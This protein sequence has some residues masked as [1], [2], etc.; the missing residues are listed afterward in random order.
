MT[1]GRGLGPWGSG[2]L[3][4]TDQQLAPIA[5]TPFTFDFSDELDGP[6]P[7]L[8]ESYVLDTDAAGDVVVTAEP[9]P[10]D[11]YSV[12]GG[13]G[14][15]EFVRTPVS[16]GPGVPFTE[17]GV[18]AGPSATLEG[19]NARVSIIAVSPT[20]ILDDTQDELFYEIAVGLRFEVLGHLWVGG[21][22]RARWAAGA[23]V[24]PLAVEVVRADGQAPVVLAAAAVEALPDP[25]DFWRVHP[26]VELE[27]VLR[28]QMVAVKVGGVWQT[29]AAVPAYGPAKAVLF[30][31]VYHLAGAVLTPIPAISAMQ[32]QSLRDLGKL[33]PP[34]Q[35]PGDSDME[36]I[37][38]L[39]TLRAPISDLLEKGYLKRVGS[40]RFEALVDFQAEVAEQRWFI[41]QGELLHAR[42][43]YVGQALVPVTRDL[44]HERGRGSL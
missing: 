17:Q 25:A 14:F 27:V 34:P 35:L 33:G 10:A 16:P 8:W 19:R 32:I 37:G 41:R 2:A 30:A 23:W 42:E 24:E 18:A 15:W 3:V 20:S 31:R 44:A 36:S 9:I 12:L 38:V 26:T 29:S 28:D 40:R 4:E 43:P 6:L 1:L 21:R 22:M 5:E 39:P 11:L 13:L 7:G